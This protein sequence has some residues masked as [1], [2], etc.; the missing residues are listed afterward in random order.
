MSRMLP[1]LS[2]VVNLSRSQL[3]SEEDVKNKVVLPLLRALGYEDADFNFE[4]RTGRGYVDVV[5]DHFPIGII[6]ETKAPGKR[7][8]SYLSQLEYY[9]FVK[10]SHDR[11]ATMAILTDGE[12]FRVYGVTEAFRAGTLQSCEI[13]EEFHRRQL[14]TKELRERLWG[15][16]ARE[17]NENGNALAAIPTYL[18]KLKEKR[19][20][21]ESRATELSELR[22]ERQRIDARIR[23]IEV[24]S[25]ATGAAALE[26]LPRGVQGSSHNDC[27]SSPASTQTIQGQAILIRLNDLRKEHNPVAVILPGL[28]EISLERS[29]DTPFTQMFIKI[30]QCLDKAQLLPPGILRP[31]PRNAALITDHSESTDSGATRPLPSG[32]H[33]NIR[34]NRHQFIACIKELI[35]LAKIEPQHVQVRIQ[36][37]GE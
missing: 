27:S 12:V 37:T 17:N 9:V 35:V 5:L 26:L 30:A 6:V 14:L 7:L 18:E 22:A 28:E 4:G 15:V 23:E 31:N 34:H 21:A 8:D 25:G 29:K 20:Q 33:L 1:D 3:V 11:K 13:I 32:R 10:H 19:E 36:P 24:L 16:L 2:Q